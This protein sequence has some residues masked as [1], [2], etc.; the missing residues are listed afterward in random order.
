M[1]EL[2]RYSFQINADVLG[3]FYD[4][5]KIFPSGVFVAQSTF[6]LALSFFGKQVFVVKFTLEENYSMEISIHCEMNSEI[7]L[8][9][10]DWLIF[11]FRIEEN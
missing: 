7:L 9:F 5:G 11:I 4:L 6:Y 2:Y 3:E 10:F 1:P 8:S